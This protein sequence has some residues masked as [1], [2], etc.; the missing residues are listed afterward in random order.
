MN[1][2][3]YSN[4]SLLGK[5]LLKE[6][7]FYLSLL[8]FISSSLIRGRLPRF[9]KD[10]VETL[11][12]LWLFLLLLKTLEREKILEFLAVK[13]L[14]GRF[15]S[16]KLLAT[17]GVLSLFVTNDI[18]LLITV[19]I[20]LSTNLPKRET[21]ISLEAIVANGLSSVSPIG[22]PQNI[23]IFHHYSL[24]VTPFI[25]EIV[26]F[27][28]AVFLTATVV[29]P[30]EDM[31]QLPFRLQ[32]NKRKLLWLLPFAVFLLSAVKILP[33]WSG[34]IILPI[35]LVKEKKAIRETDYFL[36]GTFFFLFGFTDN[37][38]SYLKVSEL[39]G[40]RLFFT[41][42]LLSQFLSNV[43]S[44]LLLSDFTSDWRSLL[45]GVSVGG[46]GTLISSM[47]NLIAYKLY[48]GKERNSRRF[49]LKF[50]VYNFSF[51]L[52]GTLLYL[53]LHR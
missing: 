53:I 33:L 21:L 36:I 3:I 29:A 47:A 49:L 50:H 41:S 22:N 18:A 13:L 9:S 52:L 28:V 2:K 43:P 27:G 24:K 44:A 4:L 16:V 31:T 8:L 46:F 17:T 14:H 51:F 1:V 37:L 48:T 11:F 12:I 10:E 15:P 19:P 20:T 23:Y 25:E 42:S 32:I 6:W 7:L 34:G 30:K 35:L 38:S 40:V 45:W 26:P 5:H 39:Q